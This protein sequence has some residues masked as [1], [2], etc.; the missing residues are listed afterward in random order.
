MSTEVTDA[1]VAESAPV[2]SVP[3]Q[4][5]WQGISSGSAG[6]GQCFT[7]QQMLERAGLDWEVGI[8]PYMRQTAAGLIPST[9]MFETYRT[10]TDD[11]VGVGELGGV[12][13]RYEL[14]Q[15]REAFDFGDAL[16]ERGLARWTHAGMQ[17]GGSKV[18]MTM[19]LN[20][21]Y[22]VLGTIPFETYL[23]LSTSHDGARSLTAFVTPINVWCTNQTAAVQR[24]NLDHFS[25]PHTK[26]AHDKIADAVN[27]LRRAGEYSNLIKEQA[28]L[29]AA[30][31]VTP[32]QARLTLSAVI[33]AR[34]PRRD[35]MIAG[36]TGLMQTSPTIADHRD[37]G[38]GL[39]NAVTEWMDHVKPQRNPNA[40]YE[41]IT[42]GEGAKL[43]L[44]V[45]RRLAR[46]N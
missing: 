28:E 7:S 37:T 1:P 43:R 17:Q 46:L 34:R 4:L 22:Q 42:F 13:S 3:R 39:L 33:P 45:A 40:R 8:R 19:L 36:I 15:N 9:R 20:E 21:R 2:V 16:I 11:Q 6:A 23:F 18:F 5:P 41:S 10:D 24:D 26:S 12:K 29:L 27:A 14:L 32:D 30:T 25:I 44:A 35:D 38:W 31:A